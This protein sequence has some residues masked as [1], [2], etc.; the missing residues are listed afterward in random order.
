MYKYRAAF[1]GLVGCLI[2]ASICSEAV[3]AKD[4][5][6]LYQA[7]CASCHGADLSG[8]AGPAL[9]GPAFVMRWG[10]KRAALR[11]RISSTMPVSSPGSLTS[12]E[13]QSITQF[14]L[15]KNASRPMSNA[16][17]LHESDDRSVRQTLL[18][19][20][21][22]VFGTASTDRP[23]DDELHHPGDGDW[24]RY[25]RDYGGQRYSPLTQIAPMNVSTL[26]PKCI[27]QTGEVGNFQSS[28]VIYDGTIYFTTAHRTFA[29]D[30]ADCHKRWSYEY[31]PAGAEGYLTNRGVA[32][33]RG[34]VIRGTTDDH[35]IA[36]DAARGILL[37]D[38]H[39]GD[40]TKGF[41]MSA[42]PVVFDG[43]LFVGEAGADLGAPCRVIAFD[44]AT[45]RHL[46]SFDLVPTGAEPGAETWGRAPHPSGAS[47]WSTITVEPGKRLLYVST[48]NPGPDWDGRE[49]PGDNLY[50]D[51]VV[52]LDADSGELRWYVQQNPHDVHDWDTVAAPILYE[53]S[54]RRFMAVGSKDARL[55]IYD[56][57][58]H[59]LIARKDLARRLNE[60][61]PLPTDHPI[62]VC[63]GVSGGVNWNGPAIDPLA[64]TIF[65]NS[66]DWCANLTMQK[67]GNSSDPL[68]G[69]YIL[70]PTSDTRGWLRA[71]DAQTGE[72]RWAYAADTSM[73][74]GVTPTA[75]GLLMTGSGSGDFLIFDSNTGKKLYSFYTG[76]AIAGGPS[77][78]LVGGKQY[79]AV[80]S[81]NNS[82][83]G[84]K[85]EGAA[86][87]VVF[88]LP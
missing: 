28:P 59:D 22:Q 66:V 37:W 14:L 34:M 45:G 72:E 39:V 1:C 50:T 18:P 82:K 77:T 47:V 69:T 23:D 46:W 6:G 73:L 56:R 52:A 86:T 74:A 63:P 8:S 36:I 29:V 57:D 10:D 4:G 17:K 11:T 24:L 7:F 53:L 21:P 84:W 76:G 88:G 25:N 42:M 20:P 49:R 16:Q 71:F 40:S 19:G 38:V 54:G 55:Y 70:D 9:S 2:A 41:F 44:A 58:T 87:L 26:A 51:A 62:H 27:L 61:L 48:G 68:G 78:Y 5:S 80:A 85:V 15:A 64:G 12:P 67:K 43:K 65:V 32:I 81:G 33:Y 83:S 13:Y 30:A 79:V 35:L 31:K 75:S 3:L 60:S